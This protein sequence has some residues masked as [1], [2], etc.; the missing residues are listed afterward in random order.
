MLRISY[1]GKSILRI[2]PN[3]LHVPVLAD[4]RRVGSLRSAE[5]AVLTSADVWGSDREILHCDA[6]IRRWVGRAAHR[7]FCFP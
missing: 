4:L 7:E 6:P 2:S 5:L 3:D 1:Y